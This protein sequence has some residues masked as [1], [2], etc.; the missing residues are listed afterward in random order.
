MAHSKIF[1]SAS[2]REGY[3]IAVLEAITS[4]AK[5]LV[6]SHEDNAA[7]F[8]V[9]EESGQIVPDQTPR[10]WAEAIKSGLLVK[11]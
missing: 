1:V 5:V 6:S 11:K 9:S 2:E 7:R 8:L 3:G 4:G 10:A